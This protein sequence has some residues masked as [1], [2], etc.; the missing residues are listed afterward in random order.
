MIPGGDRMLSLTRSFT[1]IFRNS[2]EASDQVAS[3]THQRVLVVDD[4]ID[5]ADSLVMLLKY[6][7]YTVAAAHTAEAGLALAQTFQPH[8]ILLDLGLPAMGGYEVARRIRSSPALNGLRMFAV[9]GYDH[10]DA[11]RRSTEAGFEAHLVKPINLD[12]L[13]AS[14]ACPAPAF[15]I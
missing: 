8:F 6:A 3:T 5:A 13:L 15:R 9:T 1:A 4:N 14:I 2:G 11:K 10:E 12:E 7:G